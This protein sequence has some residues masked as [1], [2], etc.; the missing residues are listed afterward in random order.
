MGP[1]R[2][3]TAWVY[4]SMKCGRIAEIRGIRQAHAGNGKAREIGATLLNSIE[5]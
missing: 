1:D 5:V 2:T 4:K 3:V